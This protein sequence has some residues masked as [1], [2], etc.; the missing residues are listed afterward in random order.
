M[1]I[2]NSLGSLS[3][4][5]I[6]VQDSWNNVPQESLRGTPAVDSLESKEVDKEHKL[7]PESIGITKEKN[8]KKKKG[9][10]R[11]CHRCGHRMLLSRLL[12]PL[13]V[14]QRKNV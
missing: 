6:S 9:K 3:A 14:K 11:V 7:Y 5:L 10:R 13:E 4:S 8:K 2:R 1:S 12:S